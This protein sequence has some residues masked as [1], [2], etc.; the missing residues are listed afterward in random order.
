MIRLQ[1]VHK[2]YP[3]HGAALTD[4]SF[5]LR[6]GEFCFLTGHSGAGKSTIM[7]LIHMAERPS[8]GEVRVGGYS[9]SSITTREVSMLRRKIGYVFQ[10]FRLL[11]D[12]TATQNIAFALEV[13]CARSEVIRSKVGRLLSH[14][15]LAARAEKL[16]SE[17]S[18][19]EQQRIAIARALV[20]DPLVVLADEPTGN[21][22]ERATAGIFELFRSINTMGT[23]VLFA[24]HNLDLVRRHTGVRVIE[25]DNGVIVYDSA[26][27]GAR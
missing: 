1:N 18:G 21:L 2:E 24:T 7:K 10:D 11:Q 12:R 6:K 23:A 13:T 15:G 14:V 17:L 25:L 22:D 8:A 26:L 5:E 20:H 19:G 3:R 27:E 9:S 16:P 4:V